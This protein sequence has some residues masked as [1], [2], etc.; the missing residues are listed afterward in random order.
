MSSPLTGRKRGLIRSSIIDVHQRLSHGRRISNLARRI[1]DLIRDLR[2]ATTGLRCLDVGCGDM[3]LAE[4][5]AALAP[6]SD[7]TCIDVHPLPPGYAEDPRWRKYRTFDG[8]RIPFSDGHFDIILFSDVLH[9]AQEDAR[10]LLAEAA[11]TG[12]TVIVKDHFER[13]L[14]SRLVLWAMDVVGNWGYGVPL[15]RRYFTRRGFEEL[16]AEAGLR[17][18][19]IEEGIDLYAHLPFL[20]LVLRP[21]WQFI[22]VLT[23]D[24]PPPGS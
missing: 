21:S 1:A 10:A 17:P 9:H 5:V 3:R 11:R 22:A 18:V 15:P 19:R 4:Q 13:S 23:P 2:S 24:R 6:G 14:W 12:G 16:A 8:R 7:W 20:R